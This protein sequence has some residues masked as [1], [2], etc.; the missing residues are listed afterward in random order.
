MKVIQII[1]VLLLVAFAPMALAAPIEPW[2]SCENGNFTVGFAVDLF[3]LPELV[4]KIN[5]TLYEK[6]DVYV[7]E[8]VPVLYEQR[9]GEYYAAIGGTP[10]VNSVVSTAEIEA[11]RL[12]PW[13]VTLCV[14]G[15]LCL[16][17][18]IALYSRGD[19]SGNS[20]EGTTVNAEG[21]EGSTVTVIV[22]TESNPDQST[23]SGASAE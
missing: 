21:K 4:A 5:D 23:T 16:L 3:A 10:D 22:Y 7:E 1:A 14:V 8:A 20:N 12:N 15:G 13:G 6:Y 11:T 17:G 2:G 18:A 19:D 9:E